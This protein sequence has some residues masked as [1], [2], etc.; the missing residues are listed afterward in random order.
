MDDREFFPEERME[1]PQCD[2]S[3]APVPVRP[4]HPLRREANAQGGA[5]LIYH[6]IMNFTVFSVVL[7][8][9][10]VKAL[11]QAIGSDMGMEELIASVLD[12]S[13]WA[14]ILSVAIGF[15]VLLLWK[16]PRYIAGTIFQKGRPMGISTFF[17]LLSFGMAAQMIGQLCNLGLEWILNLLDGDTSALQQ[18]GAADTSGLAMFLYVGII[19][20]ISEEVLFRGLVLRSLAPYGKKL[21]IFAS[22]I[23]FG[24]Y[25]GNLIQ[26]PYA[27]AVGLVLGYVALEYH[28][29]WAIAIHTFNNLVFATWL[30]DALSFLPVP[31]VDMI[32]WSVIIAFFLVAMLVLLVKREQI[33]TRWQEEK[34]E[35]WQRHLVFR[36]PTIVVLIVVCLLNIGVSTLLLFLS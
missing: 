7:V 1:M 11:S 8:T 33:V 27:F 29:I 24:L 35:A 13:G 3:F 28:V 6:L 30:P 2:E 20:P 14:Y 5:L 21:A 15:V 17:V 36:A 19:A 25:H 34:V 9:S 23:L 18:M 10:F 4:V 12:A 32:L 16:K 26:T 31:I 22:A